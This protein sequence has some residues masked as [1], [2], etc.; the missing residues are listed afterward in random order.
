MSAR[1]A[2]IDDQPEGPA[3]GQTTALPVAS[4]VIPTYDR[5]QALAHC[6][7]AVSR[8]TARRFEVIVVDDGSTDD[9]ATWLDSLTRLQPWR[10]ALRLRVLRNP[11]N[12]GANPSR[13]RGVLAAQGEIVAF[14]DSDSIPEPS[15]LEELLAGFDSQRVAAV[16]GLCLDSPARNLWELALRGSCRIATAGPTRRLVGGNMAV[17]RDLLLRFGLDDDCDF[18]KRTAGGAVDQRVSAGCDEEG[19]LLRVLAAGYRAL[20]RP[21]ARV[22]HEHRHQASSFFKQ[23]YY[24]GRSAARLVYK[25]RLAHRLDML[26]FMLAYGTAALALCNPLLWPL[27]PAFLAAGAAAIG[28]NELAR[29]GKTI[30]EALVAF[31][32]LWAYYHLRLAGYLRETLALWRHGGGIERVRL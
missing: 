1:A 24:G 32:A 9:T 10:P 4:V 5:R 3:A 2:T 17:R 19:T 26:P 31:P 29:K 22:L 13:W 12:I 6:L 16:V 18:R 8:Q 27:P 15:W 25:Y 14:L 21:D 28:Y 20:A 23:A 30:P 11:R 7:E